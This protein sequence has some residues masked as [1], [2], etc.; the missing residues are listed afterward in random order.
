MGWYAGNVEG[1]F[2]EPEVEFMPGAIAYHLHS[3]S[4]ASLRTTNQF[5]VGPFLA[6]GAT[7][8]MGCVQEPYLLFTPDVSAFL[9]LLVTKGYTFAEAA[10]AGLPALS[11]QVTIV[12]DPLYQPFGTEPEELKQ[13]L[14]A[15]HSKLAE[16]CYLRLANLSLT[17][18]RPAS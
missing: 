18:G 17:N 3:N 2:A 5:W 14:E 15:Q 12:G 6:K 1:P 11:W 4:G 9:A 10:Y 8:T 13:R 16:W 7:V